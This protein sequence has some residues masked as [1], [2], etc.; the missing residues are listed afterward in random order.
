M[1][2]LFVITNNPSSLE[3][4]EN[5]KS[6]FDFMSYRRRKLSNDLSIELYGKNNIDRYNI[7]KSRFINNENPSQQLY[8]TEPSG[9]Y[10]NTTVSSESTI[11]TY[12]NSFFDMTEEE[13]QDKVLKV[14]QAENTEFIILVPI[15][16][17]KPSEFGAD[18]LEQL[19]DKYRKWNEFGEYYRKKSN[20]LA[21]D[22]FGIDNYNLYALIKNYIM[23]KYNNHNLDIRNDIGEYRSSLNLESSDI[24]NSIKYIDINNVLSES[25]DLS[26]VQKEELVRT[27]QKI[28]DNSRAYEDYIIPSVMPF[29]TP[30]DM[31][32]YGIFSGEIN[33]YSPVPDNITLGGIPVEEWFDIY[34]RTG[35]Y[36]SNPKEWYNKLTELY[37]DFD[38]IKRSGNID[39][40]NS[41]KQSI[42][43]LCWNPEIEFNNKNMANA[44][45]RNRQYILANAVMPCNIVRYYNEYTDYDKSI[46]ATVNKNLIPIFIVLVYTE[47]PL[48][49]IIRGYLETNYAHVSMG[50]DPSLN[51]LYSFGITTEDGKSVN[52]FDI[53]SIHKYVQESK[54]SKIAVN[55]IFVTRGQYE[56]IRNNINWYIENRDRTRYNIGNLFRILINKST[57][58]KLQTNMICSQFVDTILR[59]SYINLNTKHSTNL[60]TPGDFERAK[61]PKMFTVYEGLALLYDQKRV[62]KVL[63]DL[64]TNINPELYV[65]VYTESNDIID[66][67]YD[68][69]SILEIKSLMYNNKE[70]V[71]KL[72]A[73]SIVCEKSLPIKFND[74]GD[75][76]IS[77]PQDINS[78][79]FKS[80]KLL[81]KYETTKNINGM[82]YEVARL[83]Y[84]DSIAEKHIQKVRDSKRP[85]KIS[86][87][88]YDAHSRINNDLVKYT[89]II[90][91]AE[92]NF[93]LSEYYE[94]S[95]FYH[96]NIKIHKNTID[97]IIRLAKLIIKKQP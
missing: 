19:N 58:K 40:I 29:F 95:P 96:G 91:E 59:L 43:E 63:N 41:R 3:E 14:Q 12:D 83:M 77:T 64:K 44:I 35:G 23:A 47:S 78:E 22:I 79:F 32:H 27:L 11:N 8:Y 70:F 24:E 84:L 80:H 89:K 66:K 28:N 26:F 49:K 16:W 48:A 46:L 71:D 67:V 10:S 13:W 31:D 38:D 17:G 5:E 69:K 73:E 60:V 68:A 39:K 93:N 30:D 2:D 57:N 36:V 90:F 75:V 88:Y 33:T 61:N 25:N 87:E 54:N 72:T 18:A 1:D 37:S 94:K 50:L 34:K 81:K 97:N 7:M 74:K 42:L 62:M 51:V 9:D 65:P 82:K 15:G 21:L 85:V 6:K 53:E 55:A 4:L 92:P 52:G 86:N 76:E 20:R 45:R 56:N